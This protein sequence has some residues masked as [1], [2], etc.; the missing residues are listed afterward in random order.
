MKIWGLFTGVIGYRI[1]E[2][3]EYIRISRFDGF[4]KSWVHFLGAGTGFVVGHEL[5]PNLLK[6]RHFS[7]LNPRP[8]GNLAEESLSSP[9]DG[10]PPALLTPGPTH[11]PPLQPITVFLILFKAGPAVE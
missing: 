9:D 5:L 1:V 11:F 4:E 6:R 7:T 3:R 8:H 2:Y 10:I